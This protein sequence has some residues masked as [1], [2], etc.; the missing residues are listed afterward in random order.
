MTDMKWI[1]AFLE[2]FEQM[3]IEVNRMM[4]A[5]QALVFDWTPQMKKVT[6]KEVIGCSFSETVGSLTDKLL[7]KNHLQKIT[8]EV[9]EGPDGPSAFLT[10]LKDVEVPENWQETVQRQYGRINWSKSH[11]I[12]DYM[13]QNRAMVLFQ[14]ASKNR[15]NPTTGA[16]VPTSLGDL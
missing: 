9:E 1:S 7:T 5:P 10:V 4:L 12:S 8:I 15:I 13:L 6:D 2:D 3:R 14:L 16:H 11:P